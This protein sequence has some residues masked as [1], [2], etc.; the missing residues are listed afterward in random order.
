MHSP[1]VAGAD[2]SPSA[3]APR[4]GS[5]SLPPTL[6]F[7]TGLPNRNLLSPAYGRDPAAQTGHPAQRREVRGDVLGL[8]N[9][10]A[11][12][13]T[14]ARHRRQAACAASASVFD[15]RCAGRYP[16]ASSTRQKKKFSLCPDWADA[17][18]DAVLRAR[19][20]LEVIGGPICLTPFRRHRCPSSASPWRPG[21]RR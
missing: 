5:P 12:N 17:P 2:V 4:R 1:G 13:D 10:K 16:C 14:L 7:W 21:E 3:S 15:P 18:R 11:F 9:F 8:T 6:P 19:R 20:L